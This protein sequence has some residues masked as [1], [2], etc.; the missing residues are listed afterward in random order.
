MKQYI[1]AA[2]FAAACI[3]TA[4]A[5]AEAA[6]RVDRVYW[7][8]SDVRND[9]MYVRDPWG[10]RLVLSRQWGARC[11]RRAALN[12]GFGGGCW[13]PVRESYSAW[14]KKRQGWLLLRP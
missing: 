2:G 5:G 11:H 12:Y 4:G 8:G 10:R 3:L 7:G 14:R 13:Y 6:Y 9:R 1:A